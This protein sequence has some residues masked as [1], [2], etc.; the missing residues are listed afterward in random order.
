GRVLL[1]GYRRIDARHERLLQGRRG[2]VPIR[3]FRSPRP[4]GF[5][6]HRRGFRRRQVVGAVLFPHLP[7]DE[8]TGSLLSFGL[9]RGGPF[10]GLDSKLNH[11][12]RTTGGTHMTRSSARVYMI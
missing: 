11:F 4:V 1:G 5:A 3:W 10:A 9:A 2:G 12:V 8:P 7:F 6:V